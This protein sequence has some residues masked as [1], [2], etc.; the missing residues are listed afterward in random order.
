M[1]ILVKSDDIRSGRPRLVTACI[2]VNG[3]KQDCKTQKQK[4]QCEYLLKTLQQLHGY[5]RY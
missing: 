3:L 2:K 1:L 5:I 4:Q